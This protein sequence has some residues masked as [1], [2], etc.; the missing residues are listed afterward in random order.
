MTDKHGTQL[1]VGDNVKDIK[2]RVGTVVEVNGVHAIAF[3]DKNGNDRYTFG[4][5][6]IPAQIE[7]I[8]N[9]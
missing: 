7:R 8:A 5:R 1:K 6:V 4:F 3:K 2:G 9:V